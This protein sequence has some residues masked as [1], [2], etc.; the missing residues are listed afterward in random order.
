MTPPSKTP[1]ALKEE[2]VQR[3]LYC[4]FNLR[5]LQKK[6]KLSPEKVREMG[7]SPEK[8]RE[9]GDSLLFD[10]DG[11]LLEEELASSSCYYRRLH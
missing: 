7:L 1:K 2:R 6:G 10:V 3:L 4:H 8:V 11:S 9:M 5:S